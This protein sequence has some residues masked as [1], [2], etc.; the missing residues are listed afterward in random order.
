MALT[1]GSDVVVFGAGPTGL[2]LAQLA[3]HSGAGRVTV[4]A[5]TPSKLAKAAEFG[6][7]R[8][9]RL[10]RSDPSAGLAEL[11]ALAPEGF[12]VV[13]DATGAVSVL[14]E[15]FGL[16]REGGTIVVYGM[17]AESASWPVPAYEVFRRELTIIG[18]FA[19]LHGIERALRVLRSGRVRT[20]GMITH[21]FSL[22]EY[23][24]ALAAVADS[25]CLKAVLA[26]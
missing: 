3:A 9:V 6:V 26:P 17:A 13:V 25:S 10:D 7:D 21:R 23:P 1:P 11:R 12:D 15:T 19:Q 20:D 22:D 2:L 18:S 16:V 4:A 5:P 24:D 14:E 8:T